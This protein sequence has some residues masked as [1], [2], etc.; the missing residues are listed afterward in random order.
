MARRS[1]AT[2]REWN[3]PRST[4]GLRAGPG[5][6]DAALKSL[7]AGLRSFAE[8]RAA[9][10]HGGLLRAIEAQLPPGA[11]RQVELLAPPHIRL[12]G[13]RSAPVHYR[14]DQA[15]WVAS[16]MQDFFGMRETPRV[17][18]GKVP[19]VVHLLAPNQ[20]P[21]QT[22]TDLEGFWKRLYPEVRRELARRYPRHAW[23]E[24]PLAA[25]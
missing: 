17:A 15:P 23:P 11:A 4:A 20:R 18:G 22:T 7:C 8:L 3:S 9:C 14:A 12:P 10:G 13:R 25:G 16:R 6:V 1:S 19:V 5:Y 24:D 21:V 2:W